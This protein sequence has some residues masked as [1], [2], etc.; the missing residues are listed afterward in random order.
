MVTCWD[1]TQ[2]RNAILMP[3]AA[4]ALPAAV[5]QTCTLMMHT[6]LQ[7]IVVGGYLGLCGAQPAHVTA[8]LERSGLT[9]WIRPVAPG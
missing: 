3:L 6:Q 2:H 7:V 5:E 1:G 9:R 8:V 4:G